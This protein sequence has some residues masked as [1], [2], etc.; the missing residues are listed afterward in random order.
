MVDIIFII[1]LVSWSAGLG[2]RILGRFAPVPEHPADALALAVPMGLG[3]LALSAM[4][5]AEIGLLTRGWLTAILL[6]GG[7]VAA[8]PVLDLSRKAWNRRAHDPGHAWR[9]DPH[10]SPLPGG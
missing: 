6:G 9:E 3:V 8:R 4:G 1:L 2:L 7:S 5:L 10:R